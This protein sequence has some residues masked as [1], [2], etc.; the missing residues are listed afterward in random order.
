MKKF[1]ITFILILLCMLHVSAQAE[2]AKIIRSRKVS[3]MMRFMGKSPFVGVYLYNG[4][5]AGET[6]IKMEI[7]NC[8]KTRL[9]IDNPPD[10]CYNILS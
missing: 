8:D 4:T 9:E 2:A 7:Y 5:A 1:F 6:S 10:S 3:G